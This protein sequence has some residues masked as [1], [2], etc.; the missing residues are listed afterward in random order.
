MPEMTPVS[1]SENEMF[2][3]ENALA[4]RWSISV[5][6]LRNRRVTGGFLPYVKLS[7]SVRYRLSDILSWE[8]ANT[9]Q[10]TSQG[11]QS[12]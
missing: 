6:T 10:N 5:K 2:L 1:N 9:R 8:Q 12:T 7:R 11:S 4:Q 3:D